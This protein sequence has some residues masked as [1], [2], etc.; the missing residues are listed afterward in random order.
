MDEVQARAIVS[1]LLVIESARAAG[2]LVAAP[3]GGAG[4]NVLLVAS[5]QPREDGT[6]AC[7]VV[8]V[9]VPG[10][11]DAEQGKMFP[12]GERGEWLA[13]VD[14]GATASDDDEQVYLV[15]G[16]EALTGE[17]WRSP[18]LQATPQRWVSLFQ[19]APESGSG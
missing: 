18:G 12:L 17:D 5:R 3:V 9:H 1:R 13:I 2:L 19:G 14:S 11:E 4:G 8:R 10:G 7:A 16:L 15:S 6:F